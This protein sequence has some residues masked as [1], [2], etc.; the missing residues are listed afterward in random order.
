MFKLGF[1]AFLSAMLAT[2][3]HPTSVFTEAAGVTTWI[4]PDERH[5]IRAAAA[6]PTARCGD[7]R[8]LSNGRDM[9]RVNA[10]P[11]EVPTCSSAGYWVHFRASS[12]R[13]KSRRLKNGASTCIRHP[14]NIEIRPLCPPPAVPRLPVSFT[15]S[16]PQITR[17]NQVDSLA[18]FLLWGKPGA[19]LRL[20]S[21][22][23]LPNGQY[24]LTSNFN[25]CAFEFTQA[26][27]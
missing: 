1:L 9:D 13:T 27:P 3:E 20:K 15:L 14:Y 25:R 7:E 19:P 16:R 5:G 2:M 18:P 17:R 26:C 23:K 21:P 4:D 24:L 10:D 12:G 11:Q 22:R 8:E 6:G